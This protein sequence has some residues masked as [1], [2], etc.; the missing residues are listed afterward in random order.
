MEKKVIGNMKRAMDQNDVSS[1]I[2]RTKGVHYE[3]VI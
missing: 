1:T 2:N 3:K